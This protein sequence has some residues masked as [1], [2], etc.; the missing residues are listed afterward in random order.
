ML[1]QSRFPVVV[2]GADRDSGVIFVTRRNTLELVA[3]PG[4]RCVTFVKQ[5]H[6]AGSGA[7]KGKR[8][9]S[10]PQASGANFHGHQQTAPGITKKVDEISTDELEGLFI[11]SESD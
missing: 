1:M 7:C 6:W 11:G 5:G 2:L 8:R 3:Q 9:L 10:A 4:V